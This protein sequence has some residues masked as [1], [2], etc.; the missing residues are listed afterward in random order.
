RKLVLV[1][2]CLAWS[3]GRNFSHPSFFEHHDL[4]FVFD[5]PLV[6]QLQQHFEEYWRAQDGG[7]GVPKGTGDG[8]P[9]S[10]EGRPTGGGSALS[11]VPCPPPPPPPNT[12]ARLLYSEPCNRQLAQAIYRAVDMA[13]QRIYVLNVYL[14]DSRLVY[15]LAR[16]RRRGV[17]VRVVL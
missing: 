5:G 12:W 14:T 13:H 11:R 17:D 15:K 6:G 4:S 2:G 7:K 1:D 9:E 8:K 16:A 3:G 10:A